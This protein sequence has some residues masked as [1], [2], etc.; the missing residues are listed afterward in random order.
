MKRASDIGFIIGSSIVI[1][2]LIELAINYFNYEGEGF[3]TLALRM[4]LISLVPALLAFIL[5]II[6]KVKANK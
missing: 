5:G 6:F 3:S 4:G 1:F 2:Y